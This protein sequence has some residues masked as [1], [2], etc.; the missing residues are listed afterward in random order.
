MQCTGWLLNEELLTSHYLLIWPRATT[1][2]VKK[3]TRD[4]FTELD[5]LMVSRKKIHAFLDRNGFTLDVL[6]HTADSLRQQ[7][8]TGRIN[9]NRSGIYY[10]VSDSRKYAEAP[11]NLVVGKNHLRSLADA[12]YRITRD[13]F[14]RL[15]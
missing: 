2:E 5:A 10:Y 11:I 4:D 6:V 13:G 7:G 15:P 3:L 8:K 1:N 9:T 12:H 14:E